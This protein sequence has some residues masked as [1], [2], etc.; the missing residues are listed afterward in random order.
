LAFAKGV[1]QLVHITTLDG[2]TPTAPTN[3]VVTVSEDNGATYGASDNAATTVAYGVTLLLSAT[4]TNRDVVL[5]KVASDNCDTAIQAVYTEADWS[6]TKAGY[7]DAATSSR[8]T[9]TAQQVW[10]YG[11]RTLSS[12][13][14]LVADAATAVWAAVTR[15]LTSGGGLTAQQ[16]RDAMKLAP[17]AGD[18][19]AGSIDAEL[20]DILAATAAFGTVTLT[21]GTTNIVDDTLELEVPR[22]DSYTLTA[23]ITDADGNAVDLSSYTAYKLTVKALEYR[24]D[25]DDA[26]KLFQVTGTLSGA[27]NNVLTFALTPTQTALGDL[28]VWYDCDVEVANADRS[29][30]RTLLIGRYR[31]TLDVT[32]GS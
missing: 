11:T 32:R 6:P 7:L 5:V 28:D 16:T 15:T 17:T 31:S 23:T 26:N 20:D 10:E 3:P 12:F 29:A 30:V 24:A 1:A 2:A 4:E 27:G 19:A 22:G 21:L 13:G 18:P 14:T 8:S 25:T 9:L